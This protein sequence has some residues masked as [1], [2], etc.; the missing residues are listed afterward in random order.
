LNFATNPQAE[1]LAARENASSGQSMGDLPSLVKAIALNNKVAESRELATT[2]QGSLARKLGPQ[3]KGLKDL[4]VKQA[5]FAVLIGAQMPSILSEIS[6]LTNKTDAGLLK[7]QAYRQ[8]I[9]QALC[10]AVL[11]YR[12]S[13]KKTVTVAARTQ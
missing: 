10:D 4:G 1:A 7:Q 5:P 9:A 3:S 8:R 13:L 11:A 12:A 6:F 2:V